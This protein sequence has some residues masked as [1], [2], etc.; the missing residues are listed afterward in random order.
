[1]RTL[2]L[3]VLLGAAA[4]P[5]AEADLDASIARHR[6]G[7]LVIK[8]AP[9][10][11][12][13]VE[14][15]R[16]EFW[17]GSTLPTHV[18]SGQLAAEEAARFKE[19]FARLFNAAVIENSFKWHAM[20]PQRGHV[21]YSVVDQ[22]LAWADTENVPVWAKEGDPNARLFVNDYEILTGKRVQDYAAHIW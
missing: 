2:P 18:F 17:F 4:M 6:M 12:V 11:R 16:H 5:A 22:M 13:G 21:N 20:E 19:M 9:G 10:A 1:M 15:V 3:L 14:Q 8:T 7:T